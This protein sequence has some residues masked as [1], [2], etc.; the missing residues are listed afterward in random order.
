M[1]GL[2]ARHDALDRNPVR[3]AAR[4]KL[5]ADERAVTLNLVDS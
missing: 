3:D 2:A 4:A 1:L 5:A